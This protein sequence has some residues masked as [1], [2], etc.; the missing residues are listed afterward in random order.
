MHAVLFKAHL[1]TSDGPSNLYQFLR[2]TEEPIPPPPAAKKLADGV[3]FLPLP[4]CEDYL[5]R[6]MSY[7]RLHPDP[8]CAE[9]LDVDYEGSWKSALDR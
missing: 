2:Q 3:W 8:I 7:L 5:D 4:E 6:L 1:D 9:V